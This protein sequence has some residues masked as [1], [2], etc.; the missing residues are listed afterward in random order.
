MLFTS[1][2]R[3]SL[4]ILALCLVAAAPAHAK[5]GIVFI[6]TGSELFEVA[7]FPPEVLKPGAGVPG[8]K[9]GYKCSHFGVFWADVWTW[10]CQLVAVTGDNSYADLPADVAAQLKGDS[11]YALKNAHRGFWNHYAFWT[12]VIGF[13]AL[14]VLGKFVGKKQEASP[15]EAAA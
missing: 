8:M 15:A 13:V 12:L 3:R 11:R 2:V 4:A 5:R 9:A 7:D 10:D 6:N 1:F 14:V